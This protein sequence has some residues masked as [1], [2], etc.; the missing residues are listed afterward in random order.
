VN[1]PLNAAKA[2][3]QLHLGCW[4]RHIPGFIHVDLCDLPHIDYKHGVDSLPMFQDSSVDLIYTSH[5]FEYF[6]RQEAVAVLKEYRRVLKIGGTL[7]IAVPDFE[8]LL[9]VYHRTNDLSRILG[10]LFGRMIIN[11]NTD[12]PHTLYHKTV[13]D[14]HSLKAVLEAN[15]FVNVRRYDWR[16]TVHKDYDD[17]SQAYFPH[18]DKEHGLLTSLNVEAEAA[19]KH[20]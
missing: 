6:D 9:E 16:D 8:A 17:F 14:F 18:M 5:V 20:G 13:Y 19:A 10:P 2:P 12:S 4:K 1:S 15:G 11:E 3:I 7:R